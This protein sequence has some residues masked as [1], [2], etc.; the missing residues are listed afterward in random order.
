[1]N[2]EATNINW[3]EIMD[4]F[5][6]HTGSVVGFCKENNIKQHQLYHQRQ[7]LKR[8][9]QQGFHVLEIPKPSM[10]KPH[11]PLSIR[12]EVGNIN[13]FI[14]AEEHNTLIT[15]VKELSKSC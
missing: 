13:I 11:E 3:A 4:K 7:K 6:K 5:S 10:A 2:K 15:L 1:M 9:S 12:I 14:P 8:K